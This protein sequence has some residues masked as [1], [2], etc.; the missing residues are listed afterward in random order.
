MRIGTPLYPYY[1]YCAI[2]CISVSLKGTEPP[3]I[4]NDDPIKKR[5]MM[6]VEAARRLTSAPC[7]ADT[8]VLQ[9]EADKYFILDKDGVRPPGH[10]VWQDHPDGHYALHSVSQWLWQVGTVLCKRTRAWQGN[11]SRL[12]SEPVVC[13]SALITPR[14]VCPFLT[15]KCQLLHSYKLGKGPSQS[16]SQF[17]VTCLRS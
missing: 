8:K 16:P 13:T 15:E 3:R 9:E 1:L 17:L 10:V 6:T 5:D 11:Q 14:P 12:S 7:A 2:T 4:A